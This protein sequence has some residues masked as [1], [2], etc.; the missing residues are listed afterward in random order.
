MGS[1]DWMPRNLDRRVEI[2]F[3]VESEELKRE[4]CHILDIQLEDNVKAH[5]LQPDGNYEKIDKRGKVLINS[6]E[7]F[8]QE[9]L[10]RGK[11]ISDPVADRV[12]IPAEP[13]E[14][15]EK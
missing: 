10:E 6:Q 7:Y 13:L 1:A 3:P 12:F 4:V 8:C 9:A 11:Q 2:L 14:D 15:I 5:I